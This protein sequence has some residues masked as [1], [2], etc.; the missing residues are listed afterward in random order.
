MRSFDPAVWQQ[1]AGAMADLAVAM[2]ETVDDVNKR[3]AERVAKSRELRERLRR[4]RYGARPGERAGKLGENRQIGM[5]PNTLQATD[6]ERGQRPLMLEAAEL[7][8]DRPTRTVELRGA[9]RVA[10]DQRVQPVGLD[11]R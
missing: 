3:A 4:E 6:A 7:P 11:P 8:L 5:Q 10:R 2:A 9:R 1:Q